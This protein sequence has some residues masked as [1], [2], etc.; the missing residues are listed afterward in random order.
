MPWRDDGHVGQGRFEVHLPDEPECTLVADRFRPWMLPWK[1]QLGDESW[2]TYSS[3]LPLA[4]H[5]LLPSTLPVHRLLD[6]RDYWNDGFWEGAP[7]WG[8]GLSRQVGRIGS[9]HLVE[10]LPGYEQARLRFGIEESG[11]YYDGPHGSEVLGVKLA[12]KSGDLVDTVWWD[13]PRREGRLQADWFELL[14]LHGQAQRAAERFGWLSEWKRRGTRRSIGVKLTA[15]KMIELALQGSPALAWRRAGMREDPTIELS[16]SEFVPTRARVYISEVA[17][18]AALVFRDSRRGG[19]GD[20]ARARS[21]EMLDLERLCEQP[22]ALGFAL[23]DE[24]GQL[25]PINDGISP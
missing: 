15:S 6:G 3:A 11:F 24:Q 13:N 4:L 17:P 25:L 18:L 19:S 16:L 8:S 5:E 20:D 10:G 1:V 21:S 23:A 14:Q 2:Q 22:P 12:S 9:R 7:H